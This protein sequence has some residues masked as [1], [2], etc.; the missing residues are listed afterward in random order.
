MPTNAMYRCPKC[1]NQY[2]PLEAGDRRFLCC[3]V[4]L[5]RVHTGGGIQLP[6]LDIGEHSA[7]VPVSARPRPAQ[8]LEVIEII[9]PRENTVDVLAV[10][11]MLATFSTEDALFSLEIAGDGPSRHLIARGTPEGIAHIRRQLQATYDQVSFR[12]LTPD[13]DPARPS[14]LPTA[15][16]HLT[17]ARPAYLPLRTYENGDFQEADPVRGLLGAF[18]GL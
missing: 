17:L 16:A 8:L 13:Q 2:R 4:P 3:G 10:Q 11:M 12:T 7:L 18:D 6:R 14:H 9:P 15:S 1:K 5:E